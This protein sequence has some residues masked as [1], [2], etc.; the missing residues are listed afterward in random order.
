MLFHSLQIGAGTALPGIIAAKLGANVTLTDASHFPQCQKN[1]MKSC[2]LNNVVDR[3]SIIP[4]TWG[5]FTPSLMELPNIDIILG[6]DCFYNPSGLCIIILLFED[7]Y[8]F[9]IF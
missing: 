6:S 2:R 4:L 9:P 1:A 8:I 7:S 5:D 3:V